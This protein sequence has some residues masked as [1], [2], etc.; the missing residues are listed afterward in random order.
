MAVTVLLFSEINL[1]RLKLPECEEDDCDLSA[2]KLH[3]FG[4]GEKQG[5]DDAGSMALCGSGFLG[6][7]QPAVADAGRENPIP[8]LQPGSLLQLLDHLREAIA[9]GVE[10]IPR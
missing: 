3:A 8:I 1:P 7:R 9:L 6:F 4:V 10:R 5:W 2:K